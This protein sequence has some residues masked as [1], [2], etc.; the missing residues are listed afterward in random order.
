MAKSGKSKAGKTAGAEG[1]A[2]SHHAGLIYTMVL[3]SAADREMTDNEMASIGQDVLRLPIFRDFDQNRLPKVAA[4]CA[5]LLDS[6]E[7]LDTVLEFIARSLPDRLRE[8]AY[9]LACEIAAADGK[10]TPEESRI[11]EL[12]RHKLELGRLVSAAI[13]RGARA[14]AMRL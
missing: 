4:E 1:M 3:V 10:V 14:R 6:D 11:L 8:T 5:E 9:A 13:E 2:V 7:G 12:I